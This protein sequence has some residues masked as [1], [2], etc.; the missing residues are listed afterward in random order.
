MLRMKK[1]DFFFILDETTKKTFL[2]LELDDDM[3]RN[4]EIVRDNLKK[5]WDDDITFHHDYPKMA[6][7]LR[8]E[9]L[10]YKHY[11]ETPKP[12]DRVDDFLERSNTAEIHFLAN[13]LVFFNTFYPPPEPTDA[14]D[15]MGYKE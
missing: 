6:I 5:A 10:N 14:L 3:K 9:K 15:E 4:V 2:D 7:E 1:E 11:M 12:Y 8:F 13:C